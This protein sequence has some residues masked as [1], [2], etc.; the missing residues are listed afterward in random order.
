MATSSGR[1]RANTYGAAPPPPPPVGILKAPSTSMASPRSQSRASTLNHYDLLKSEKVYRQ[2]VDR[3]SLMS[4]KEYGLGSVRSIPVYSSKAIHGNERDDSDYDSP[5][6]D[7]F[8]SRY[9]ERVSPKSQRGGGREGEAEPAI[10]VQSP[11]SGRHDAA[12]VRT[13]ELWRRQ[14]RRHPPSPR[15]PPPRLTQTFSALNLPNIFSQQSQL[16]PY[17]RQSCHPKHPPLT[18]SPLQ[19]RI[20]ASTARPLDCRRH[21][22]RRRTLRRRYQEEWCIRTPPDGRSRVRQ[23]EQVCNFCADTASERLTRFP[24]A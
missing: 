19:N 10:N 1:P 2:G 18:P 12:I 17:C 14:R 20:E 15:L 5:L 21:S 23:V 13:I 11:V 16:S 3:E 24:W 8:T 9:R 4:G 22:H 7:K 6:L